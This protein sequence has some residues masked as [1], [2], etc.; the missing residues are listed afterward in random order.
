MSNNKGQLREDEMIITLNGKKIKELNPNLREMMENLFGVIEDEKTIKCVKSQDYIKPD[1][2]IT[3]EGLTMGVSIKSGTASNVHNEML[4]TFIDYLRNHGISERTIKTVL[5]HHYG[6]GTSDGTGSVRQEAG[7]IMYHLKSELKDAN[8]ELN[9]NVE[10]I[11]DA[12]DRFMFQGV[13]P[14]AEKAKAIYIGDIRFGFLTAR[15][16]VIKCV[17]KER[18]DYYNSLHI[19]PLLIRPHARYANVE[20][21]SEMSRNRIDVWWPHLYED[22]QRISRRYYNYTPLHKRTRT[23]W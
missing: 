10:F 16:Q 9:E 5:L 11:I 8:E 14:E 4:S 19:G 17:S 20:V 15:S 22:L 2:D 3:Y 7:E 6:D 13:D 23:E 12:V 21:K 1:I 18:W